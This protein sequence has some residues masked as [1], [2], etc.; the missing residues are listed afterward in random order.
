MGVDLATV[1]PTGV[2]GRITREDV[3]RAVAAPRPSIGR[4]I[5]LAGM[6][7]AVADNVSRSIRNAPH[8]TL[9][10][11]VDMT[12]SVH[13][14]KQVAPEL[15]KTHGVK[16]SFTDMIVKAAAKAIDD[17]PLVNATL[18]DDQITVHDDIDIGVAV[19]LDDGLIAPIIRTCGRSRSPRYP[20][21]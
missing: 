10:S 9:V 8:V 18:E 6:R 19:A 15:E 21:R 2:S 17:H 12:E 1:Q 7:K 11:E 5:P 14:R 4:V 20:L 13:L 16:I 3:M